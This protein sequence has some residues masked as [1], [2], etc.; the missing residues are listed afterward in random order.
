M[1][2]IAGVDIRVLGADRQLNAVF[3][4]GED[5]CHLHLNESQ[6]EVGED[7]DKGI[8]AGEG[9]AGKAYFVIKLDALNGFAVGLQV[10]EFHVVPFQIG[11]NLLVA[12]GKEKAEHLNV[13]GGHAPGEL[14]GIHLDAVKQGGGHVPVRRVPRPDIVL[15]DQ[16]GAGPHHADVLIVVFHGDKGGVVVDAGHLVPDEVG[17]VSRQLLGVHIEDGVGLL[18][19]GGQILVGRHPDLEGIQHFGGVQPV[20]APVIAQLGRYPIEGQQLLKAVGRGD[21]VGVGEVVGLDV[22]MLPVTQG[23]QLV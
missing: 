19:A 23:N 5:H 4:K 22:D 17:G 16:R 15:R 8:G 7:G 13:Q 12:E 20:D 2:Q 6:N 10:A 11:Q 21:G 18:H 14:Q 3:P 9:D 1:K